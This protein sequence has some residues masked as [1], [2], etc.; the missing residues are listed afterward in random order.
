VQLQV[1]DEGIGIAENEKKK[2]FEKF[3]RSGNEQ[4]RKT[5]G[6][7]LGLF[8]CKKIAQSHKADI[9]ITDNEKGGSIFT[10]TF[11]TK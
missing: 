5:Q 3:Y 8:I 2:V 7:G 11:K 6:T 1:I 10:V 4:T 9:S